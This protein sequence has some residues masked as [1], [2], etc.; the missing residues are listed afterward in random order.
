MPSFPGCSGVRVAPDFCLGTDEQKIL[1]PPLSTSVP[2]SQIP[3]LLFT[4]SVH[5]PEHQ[6]PAPS[7]PPQQHTLPTN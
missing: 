5:V 2:P 7:C 1:T 6:P 3:A 4:A